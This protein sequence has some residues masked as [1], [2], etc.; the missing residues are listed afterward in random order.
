MTAFGE[1]GKK[2]E[3]NRER[4]TPITMN[5]LQVSVTMRSMLLA[6]INLWVF[7]ATRKADN[8]GADR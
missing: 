8:V 6:T 5:D 7:D 1:S 3:M 4:E 2:G